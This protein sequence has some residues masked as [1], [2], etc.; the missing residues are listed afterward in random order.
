MLQR[1]GNGNKPRKRLITQHQ[2]RKRWLNMKNLEHSCIELLRT[3]AWACC[4]DCLFR[5]ECSRKRSNICVVLKK[6]LR[7]IS[8]SS[9]TFFSHWNNSLRSTGFHRPDRWSFFHFRH[10][11]MVGGLKINFLFMTKWWTWRLQHNNHHW[12]HSFCSF[13]CLLYYSWNKHKHSHFF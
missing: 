6:T 3:P 1:T 4:A 5:T 7:G 9:K 2:S 8:D 12:C 10:L 11:N 13:S